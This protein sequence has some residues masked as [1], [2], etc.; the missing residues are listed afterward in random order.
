M[1][2]QHEAVFELHPMFKTQCLKYVLQPTVDFGSSRSFVGHS[3]S[4]GCE[5]C[6]DKACELLTVFNGNV[7]ISFTLV[8]L[9][10]RIEVCI[11]TCTHWQKL[12]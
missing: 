2:M 5:L 8:S 4:I 3:D 11:P 12:P 6:S 7:A 10:N 1:S 9:L